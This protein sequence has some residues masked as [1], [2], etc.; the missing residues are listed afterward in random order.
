VSVLLGVE[1]P[2]VKRVLE[3]LKLVGEPETTE[4]F[5]KGKDHYN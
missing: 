3:D 4:S 5:L 1:L 2:D